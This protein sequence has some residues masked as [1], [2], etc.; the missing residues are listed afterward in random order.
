M[1]TE[2]T[3]SREPASAASFCSIA[4]WRVWVS[5]ECKGRSLALAYEMTGL[6]YL[7]RINEAIDVPIFDDLSGDLLSVAN[8]HYWWRDK[9]I[10]LSLDWMPEADQID[11]LKDI[12]WVEWKTRDLCGAALPKSWEHVR[13]Q[14]SA[15]DVIQAARRLEK[16]WKTT[17]IPISVAEDAH[18]CAEYVLTHAEKCE[19]LQAIINRLHELHEVVIPRSLAEAIEEEAY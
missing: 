15:G 16:K 13:P 2:A 14:Q 8:I 12:G 1:T 18:D 7:P 17:G 9:F 19:R 6:P 4:N 3:C 11:R 5:V 10:T